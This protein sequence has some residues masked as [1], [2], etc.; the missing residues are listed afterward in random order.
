MKQVTKYFTIAAVALFAM[1]VV[2]TMAQDE[3]VVEIKRGEVLRVVG[4]TLIVR[5]EGEGVKSVVVPPDFT[6]NNDGEEISVQELRPGMQLTSVKIRTYEAAQAIAEQDVEKAAA[7]AARSTPTAD[8][9][10]ATEPAAKAKPAPSPQAQAAP[11]ATTQEASG[12]SPVVIAGLV[13][14]ALILIV[15]AVTKLRKA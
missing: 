2:N 6:F 4:N 9:E 11:A 15:I 12:L 13:L 1:G 10:T 3:Q 7:E 14:M 8:P 5:V